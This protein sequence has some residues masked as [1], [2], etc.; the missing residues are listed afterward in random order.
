MKFGY[1]KFSD[2]KLSKA[3]QYI[4]DEHAMASTIGNG[5]AEVTYFLNNILIKTQSDA[6]LFNEPLESSV[7]VTI[8][9]AHGKDLVEDLINLIRSREDEEDQPPPLSTEVIQ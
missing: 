4:I 5:V 7:P 9:V 6:D 8:V 3:L 2:K 1:K